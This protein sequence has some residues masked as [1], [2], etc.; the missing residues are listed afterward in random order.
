LHLVLR[1]G[2]IV[3]GMMGR[4]VSVV[5]VKVRVKMEVEVDVEVM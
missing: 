5:G 2:G 3:M 1:V 4:R